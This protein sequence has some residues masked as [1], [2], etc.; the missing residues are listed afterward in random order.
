MMRIDRKQLKDNDLQNGKI[1]LLRA[2]IH[3]CKLNT[4]NDEI[5]DRLVFEWSCFRH[6]LGPVF[7]WSRIQMPGSTILIRFSNGL[8]L[9]HFIIKNFLFYYKTV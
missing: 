3:I 8:K 1:S 7:E 2:S 6:F 5:P 4:V 9:D